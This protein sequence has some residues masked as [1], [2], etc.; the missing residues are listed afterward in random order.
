M[1][2]HDCVDGKHPS[3]SCEWVHVTVA[4]RKPRDRA[5]PYGVEQAFGLQEHK[6]EYTEDIVCDV[7]SGCEFGVAGKA[8]DF[9]YEGFSSFFGHEH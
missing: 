1:R 4:N 5:P 6:D 8:H 3:G 9:V 2:T 7:Q